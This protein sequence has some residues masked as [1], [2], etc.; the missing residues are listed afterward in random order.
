MSVKYSGENVLT[1]LLSLLNTKFGTKVDKVD[2]KGLS[3]NDYT[4][5]EKQKLAGIADNANN[6]SHPAYTQRNEG[7]YKVTV[8]AQ[9]HVSNVSAVEKG[10]ITALGIPAQDTTYSDATESA[11]GLMP[12]SA[13]TKL[14]GIEADA[15]V[16]IIESVKVNGSALTVTDKAVDIPVPTGALASKSQVAIDDLNTELKEKVLASS[17]GNHGHTNKELL[18]TYTQ[19]EADLADAVAKKHSHANATELDKI[20]DGDVAKWN[21]AEQ[22]AKDYADDLDEAMDGRMQIV[23]GK[24]HEHANAAE[25]AKFV[26]GDKA[27]LDAAKST[28]DAAAAAIEVLNGTE[29]TTGSVANTVKTYVDGRLASA[30]KAAGSSTFAALPTPSAANEGYVYNVTDAFTT[31]AKFVDAANGQY[32]AG[33]N[34][35]V[36]EVSEGVYKFDVLAGFVDLSNYM[37]NDDFAELTNT[38]VQAIW[39]SVFAAS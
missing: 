5:A 17:E 4:T 10:D 7:L 11:A 3:T 27:K 19:T 33:T 36:V 28:A 12:A 2:G 30:Y 15:D 23:E 38:E 6:Y 35:V 18:E 1:Y 9:G 8:D 25:L 24:A 34:V 22:N 20:A 32:A 39:D 26:D 29:S 37:Q 16:N 13:V 31:D 14:K 21:A